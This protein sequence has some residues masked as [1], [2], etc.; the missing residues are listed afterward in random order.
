[1]MKALILNCRFMN[2]KTY[3]HFDLQTSYHV[4]YIP[5]RILSGVFHKDICMLDLLELWNFG[6]L[7]EMM[8]DSLLEQYFLLV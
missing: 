8:N 7:F 6:S 2:N 5:S 1:M 4:R 3:K